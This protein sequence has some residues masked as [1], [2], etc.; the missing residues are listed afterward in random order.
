MA[1]LCGHCDVCVYLRENDGRWDK[2]AVPVGEQAHVR[3]P[4][5]RA[6]GRT[7]GSKLSRLPPTFPTANGAAPC[8]MIVMFRAE[9]QVRINYAMDAE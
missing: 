5:K 4:S 1:A 9:S 2:S 3:L 7:S 8:K 6:G